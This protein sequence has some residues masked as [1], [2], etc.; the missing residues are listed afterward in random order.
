MTSSWINI[1]RR[2]SNTATAQW[3]SVVSTYFTN[4]SCVHNW[5]FENYFCLNS[6]SHHSTRSQFWTY[7]TLWPD[8]IIISYVK[9][10]SVFSK[11]RSWAHKPFVTWVPGPSESFYMI[12]QAIIRH[13]LLMKVVSM[14]I[15]HHKLFTDDIISNLYWLNSAIYSASWLGLGFVITFA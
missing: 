7:A 3:I 8:L 15:R 9:A 11:L 14:D 5:N 12:D 13:Y 4:G 10:N 2:V 1:L 6:D